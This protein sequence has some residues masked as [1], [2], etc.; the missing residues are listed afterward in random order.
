[1]ADIAWTDVTARFPNDA[2]LAAVDP[3]VAGAGWAALAN[4]LSAS[5]FGG[6]DSE[7]YKTA[8]ILYAAHFALG[9][10]TG[11]GQVAAGPVIE[12]TEGGVTERYAVTSTTSVDG[13]HNATS[14]G[15]LFDELMRSCPRRLGVTT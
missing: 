11:G 3:D 14:Y 8:R 7:K 13:V 4:G 6:K 10:G 5:F 9:G 2:E 1:M 15:R 12:Q